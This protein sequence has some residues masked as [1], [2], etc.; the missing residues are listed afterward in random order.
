MKECML[1]WLNQTGI[2]LIIL[3]II[4]NTYFVISILNNSKVI[5]IILIKPR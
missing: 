1:I 2:K 3:Q 4:N 5:L